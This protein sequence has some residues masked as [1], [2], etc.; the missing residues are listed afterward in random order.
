MINRLFAADSRREGI[1]V[2]P[3][4]SGIMCFFIEISEVSVV[5]CCRCIN[6]LTECPCRRNSCG[7]SSEID[8]IVAM[9]RNRLS[10]FYM[11]GI[12]HPRH[13]ISRASAAASAVYL[14]IH[15]LNGISDTFKYTAFYPL[16]I[17]RERCVDI[18][19]TCRVKF[20]VNVFTRPFAVLGVF[21]Y[22]SVLFREHRDSCGYQ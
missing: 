16:F 14:N 8:I 13:C 20:A 19:C 11:L 3:V 21:V 12:C 18:F 17:R 22:H 15:I 1:F 5:V 6:T 4:I 7:G 10:E 9:Y 2:I